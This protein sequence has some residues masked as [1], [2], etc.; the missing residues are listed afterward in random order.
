M[1]TIRDIL[2]KIDYIVG[3][4]EGVS[5]D[6]GYL[7]DEDYSLDQALKE[8]SELLLECKPTINKDTTYRD[9]DGSKKFLYSQSKV[10]GY[11]QGIDDYENNIK[12]IIGGK[13]V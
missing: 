12:T 7:K 6:L 10:W 11:K 3:E 8:I 4:R 13:D 1:K 2:D 9:K 5:L